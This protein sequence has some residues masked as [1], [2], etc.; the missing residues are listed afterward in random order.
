VRDLSALVYHPH[1][2]VAIT[3]G[4]GCEV[5][6]IGIGVFQCDLLFALAGTVAELY[7][8]GA[9]PIVETSRRPHHAAPAAQM[10][11]PAGL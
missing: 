1:D 11:A 5:R 8:I 6:G 2:A 7:I 4:T 9:I 10:D 3:E